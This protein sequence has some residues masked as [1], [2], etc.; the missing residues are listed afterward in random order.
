[1]KCFYEPTQDAIGTCK[2]C[3]K[4]LSKE[5]AVDLGKG[6]ACKGLCEEDVKNIINLVD[7]NVAMASTAENLTTASGKNTYAAALLYLFSG[8]AF[9]LI[10]AVIHFDVIPIMLGVIFLAYGGFMLTR[11]RSISAS[12][13]QYQKPREPDN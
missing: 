11:A 13:K 7:R 3:G 12:I 5:Y 9:F 6:L 1:M 4:G 10:G 8:A 2:N